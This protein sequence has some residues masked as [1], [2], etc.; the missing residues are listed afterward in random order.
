MG[1]GGRMYNWVLDSLTN[2]TYR[3]KVGDAVLDD[4]EIVNGIPQ[5]NAISPVLFN[6]MIHDV[7][8]NIGADIGSSVYA[9]KR[10]TCSTCH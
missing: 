8:E 1:I 4:F 3:V 5:S 9:E 7:F 6:I 2:W 10:G